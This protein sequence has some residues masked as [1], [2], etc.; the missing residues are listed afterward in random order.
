MKPQTYWKSKLPMVEK[1]L[2]RLIPRNGH[3][4]LI[5]EAMRYSLLAGGKRLRPIL[6]LAAARAAGG[7]ETNA[8]PGA[9]AVECIH[10]YSL[11]HDDLPCMDDDDFRRGRP[12]NHKVYG[13]AVAV[14]A[15]DGLLTEAF[16]SVARIKP[17]RRYSAADFVAELAH[18]SGSL[19]L[20]AGQVLDLDSEKKRIPLK[21]LVE[22]HRAKTGALITTSLRL[23]AM[24]A[25]ADART[26]SH[27][28]RFGRALGLAF[29]VIDDILDIVST[30]E[31]LGK[32]IG[33]DQ[34]SGKA[35]YPR[36]LGLEGA[37]HEA[38][39]LTRAAR[40]ALRPLGTRAHALL[41]IADALLRRDH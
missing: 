13:E 22:I 6:C 26:L 21:K 36:L 11:I 29:Q 32:S 27:L 24:S 17:N 18:A 40:S 8:L 7:R 3:P 12:T 14:L 2:D 39:R 37:R 15:G 9:C 19:G 23:G 30:K 25:G 38:D 10:T 1:A 20:I 28:T 31:K 5:H 16:A 34:S 35:T 41:A 4:R 33:K